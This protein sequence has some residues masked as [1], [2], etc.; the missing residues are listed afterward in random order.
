MKA[1]M[2]SDFYDIRSSL[3]NTIIL[4]AFSQSYFWINIYQNGINVTNFIAPG[5]LIQMIFSIIMG[6]IVLT[7]MRDKSIE[8][9]RATPVREEDYVKAKFLLQLIMAGLIFIVE[10]SIIKLLGN[11]R[12]IF[13]MIILS[14]TINYLVGILYIF[15]SIKFKN[16][17]F[18]TFPVILTMC[19]F[20]VVIM[21]PNLLLDISKSNLIIPLAIIFFGIDIIMHM[22]LKKFSI[23]ELKSYE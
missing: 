2:R 1:I 4:M 9:L 6:G 3:L 18:T 20:A 19:I 11:D 23:K 14:A 16:N 22:V 17:A 21:F 13:N 7:N 15:I 12:M 10:I 5:F 8:Y